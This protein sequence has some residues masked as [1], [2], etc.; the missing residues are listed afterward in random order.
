MTQAMSWI[1]FCLYHLH[2]LHM[3]MPQK[4]GGSCTERVGVSGVN[5]N[6]GRVLYQEGRYLAVCSYYI[7]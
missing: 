2:R 5:K 3:R 1:Y 4:V 6:C 7:W